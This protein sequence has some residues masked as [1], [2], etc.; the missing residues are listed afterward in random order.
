M[1]EIHAEFKVIDNKKQHNLQ[2]IKNF[3]SYFSHNT[4][5]YMQVFFNLEN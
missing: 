3:G 4:Y 1:N 5:N 2:L